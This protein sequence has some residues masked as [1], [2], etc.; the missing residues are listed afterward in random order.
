MRKN[1]N[2]FAR[3]CLKKRATKATLVKVMGQLQREVAGI[4]SDD[5][6]SITQLK[7][8]DSV[9]D[10]KTVIRSIVNE[11][12]SKAPTLLSLFRS[13]LKT[14]KPKRNTE[15]MV[16]VLMSIVCKHRRPSSCIM[17]RIISLILYTGHSS[18]QVSS[19][20]F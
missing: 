9:R 18:K 11:M 1:Y 13:C 16:A 14:K 19:T 17:Q 7:S 8:K 12:M 20:S 6:N 15:A 5:F 2:S 4:S 3:Q 10:F